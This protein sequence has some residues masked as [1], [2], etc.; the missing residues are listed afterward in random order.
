MPA[1]TSALMALRRSGRLMVRYITPLRISVSRSLDTVVSLFS[2][3]RRR[4]ARR[5]LGDA[6]LHHSSDGVR[7]ITGLGEN[8]G[9]VF[10]ELGRKADMTRHRAGPLA[11]YGHGPDPAGDRMLGLAEET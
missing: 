1:C 9:A 7:G 10:A 4:L 5:R 6:C 11:R 2:L 8:L 3:V